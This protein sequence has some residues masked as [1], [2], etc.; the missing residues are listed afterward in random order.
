MA[1]EKAENIKKLGK[2]LKKTALVIGIVACILAVLLAFRYF[3]WD[4]DE[5]RNK[6]AQGQ[7]QVPIQTT[8]LDLEKERLNSQ[9]RVEASYARYANE[10]RF[11]ANQGMA[12]DKTDAKPV[13]VALDAKARPAE[14]DKEAAKR[15]LAEKGFSLTEVSHKPKLL[16][17]G[18]VYELDIPYGYYIQYPR[19][20]GY[21]KVTVPDKDNPDIWIPYEKLTKK[22]QAQAVRF[23]NTGPAEYL[24]Q[25]TM[26][27]KHTVPKGTN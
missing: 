14:T 2:Y 26:L 9:L 17:P 8:A 21:V 20:N 22:Y 27:R 10:E 25:I 5:P 1:E 24:L 6:A 7:M 16:K 11:K 4:L 3:G 23:E 13:P 19:D 12:A 15:R 18:E